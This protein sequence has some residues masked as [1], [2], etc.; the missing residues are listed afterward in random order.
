VRVVLFWIALLVVCAG[1]GYIV[2]GRTRAIVFTCLAATVIVF[3]YAL[4]VYRLRQQRNQ[5][6]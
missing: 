2:V 4:S 6:G 3:T 1:A 5:T